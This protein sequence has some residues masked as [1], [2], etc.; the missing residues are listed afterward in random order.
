MLPQATTPEDDGFNTERQPLDCIFAPTT[1][2]V[3]GAT[4]Q[5]GSVGR[6]IL[7]NLVTAS[8]GKTIF[9]VHPQRTS[10]LGIKAYPTVG[11]VPAVVDLAIIA[12]P[13]ATVPGIVR[14]CV[15][16]RVKGAIILSAGFRETGPAGAALEEQILVE[17]R[18][19][20][21]RIIGPNCLGVMRPQH[22]L[23]A[24]FAPSMAQ[25]GKVAFVSQSGALCTAVLD[26]S[27]QENVGFSAFISVGSMLDVNWGDVIDYLGSDRH[28]TSIVMYMESIGDVRAFLGAAREVARTKPI[29]VLKTGRTEEAARAATSHTGALVGQDAVFDAALSRCGVLRVETVADLF[30]MA[31]VLGKQ[32]R[33]N[34][35]RL[36]VVTN[37]GGPGVLATDALIRNGGQLAPLSPE[38]MAAVDS[39]LPAHWSHG[40][41]IDL[42]GDAD[43]QRLAQVLDIVAKD[44]DSDGLLVIVTPQ[45]TTDPA[46]MA[47]SVL[48]H[49]KVPGKP[50][51]A[52]WMGGASMALGTVMLN[53]ANIPTFAY[54]DTAA[55]MFTYMWRY[56]E[57]LRRLYETPTR[58]VDAGTDRASVTT[59]IHAAQRGGRV[60]LT[61]V[62]AK[63]VISA[64]GI[65]AV[66]TE[67]ATNSDEAVA[68]ADRMG[69]PVVL[70]VFST[71]ITHKSDIGGVQLDLRD[72]SAV[73]QAYQDIEAAVAKRVGSQTFE[74]VTVQAM[75]QEAGYELIIGSTIDAQFGPVILFGRGGLLVDVW[76]DQ[77]LALPPLTTTLAHQLVAGTHIFQAL[78][79]LRGRS[80]VDLAALEQV[81]VRFSYLLVEQPQ[82]KEIDINPLLVTPELIVALDARI[83]LHP[84]DAEQLP[85]PVIRPYPLQYVK[86]WKLRDGTPVTIRPIRPE[87]EPLLVQFHQTLSDRSVYMR[88]FHSMPLSVRTTHER[89]TRMCF[90]DYDR[91]IAL[92]V[93]PTEPQSGERAIIAVG[94]LIKLPGTN[95]AEW[96]GLVSDQ[97][98]GQGLGGE[99][100]RL[101]IRVGK[102]EH[103]SRITA[104]VLPENGAMRRV[105][106][107]EGFRF[108]HNTEDHVVMAELR[109]ANTV[110]RNGI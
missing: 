49:A 62:E 17:A 59:I 55:R 71:T 56:S 80:P 22:G 60:L 52:S 61:E 58:S 47:Q 31:E 101:L 64:Y 88:Y 29:I 7:W 27:L 12:T 20:K 87:D 34:G 54:P 63:R 70:K 2:A 37:A 5:A 75:V 104:E 51:L 25:A 18:R 24:S 15:T 79:G 82:I 106:A 86:Q 6:S 72:G 26:W 103:L 83:V 42:L 73:L 93:E 91:E 94:R 23:N 45:V 105:F 77:A 21:L 96:A 110:A 1:V 44:A 11:A 14:E 9:P 38:A 40:N 32:P 78:K 36:M 65:P 76:S 99:L 48:A 84:V 8:S 28:T 39:L 57:N 92:V 30:H 69:Y 108:R 98:Q 81:L 41:P 109:L 85:R 107:K 100:L 4:D 50:V 53:R 68:L 90:I 102:D 74:G 46:Q 10:V 35:P 33:P 89:L 43:P 67:A 95:D 66:P 97:F 16:A 19:G 13:A 3:I